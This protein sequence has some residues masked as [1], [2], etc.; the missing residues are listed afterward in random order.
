MTALHRILVVLLAATLSFY[1]VSCGGG[2]DGGAN[3]TGTATGTFTSSVTGSDTGTSTS[4][5]T[6]TSTGTAPYVEQ[7]ISMGPTGAAYPDPEILQPESLMTFQTL[8]GRIWVAE[9]DQVTGDFVSADGKDVLIDTRGAP[10]GFTYNGPEFGINAQ[11]WSLYYA[12]GNSSYTQVWRAV[13]DGGDVTNTQ[14]TTGLV[15]NN[16][17]ATKN[18]SSNDPVKVMCVR[19]D[20][21]DL[22]I[23]YFSTDTPNNETYVT[24]HDQSNIPARWAEE[25]RYICARTTAGQLFLIDTTDSSQTPVTNDAGNKTDPNGWYAPDYGGD[26]I[27]AAVLDDAA[28]AVYRDTG[29]AYWERITTLAIPAESDM[30]EV[31]SPEPFVAGGKSYLSLTIKDNSSNVSEVWLMSV[32]GTWAE[33]CGDGTAVRR[34][35]PEVFVGSFYVFVYYYLVPSFELRR[36]RSEIELG[37]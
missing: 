34:A 24:P 37:P 29:G 28:I 8:D 22:D 32:D 2:S 20:L 7:L 25:G 6:G 27:I 10:M 18:T 9:L 33:R 12:V 26:M 5:D 21:P 1:L 19:F 15:H 30:E 13:V 4:T 35:D 31:G 11:G 17:L 23:V 14:L 16:Q 3:D 36:W